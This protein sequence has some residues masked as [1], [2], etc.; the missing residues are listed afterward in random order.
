MK[1]YMG[2]GTCI[3]ERTRHLDVVLSREAR[4][5]FLHFTHLNVI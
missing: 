2:K 3:G 4:Y 1:P 5:K